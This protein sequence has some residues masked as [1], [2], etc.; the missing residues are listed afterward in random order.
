M[1][2][3][4]CASVTVISTGSSPLRLP[5]LSR[6]SAVAVIFQTPSGI[7]DIAEVSFQAAGRGESLKPAHI[8]PACLPCAGFHEEPNTGACGGGNSQGVVREGKNEPG[9][10]RGCE[11]EPD[12]EFR[13]R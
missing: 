12:A 1:S 6:T 4:A 5:S 3:L 9:A 8:D 2:A 7:R 11:W 13:C 10:D